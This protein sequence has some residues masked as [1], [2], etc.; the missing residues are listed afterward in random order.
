MFG[1]KGNAL[2]YGC[3]SQAKTEVLDQHIS[4][5]AIRITILFLQDE[6]I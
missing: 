3:N 2:F 1:H 6:R 5:F 4:V